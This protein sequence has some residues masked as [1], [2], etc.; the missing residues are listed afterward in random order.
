MRATPLKRGKP[1]RR[2]TWMRSRSKTNAYRRR[3]RDIDHMLTTKKLPCVCRA[4]VPGDFAIAARAAG[5][6]VRITP[7]GGRVEADHLGARGLGQKADD[8]SVAPMCQSHHRERTD[9]NGAFRDLTRDEARAWRAAALDH[10][11]NAWSSK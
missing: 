10:T 6:E 9:H 11:Q 5:A 3:E 4:V 7:C 2:K 1:L 8:K